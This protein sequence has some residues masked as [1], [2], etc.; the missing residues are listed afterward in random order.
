MERARVDLVSNQTGAGFLPSPLPENV[1][2]GFVY[3]K[4][5]DS[6]KKK[7]VHDELTLHAIQLYIQ[8]SKSYKALTSQCRKPNTNLLSQINH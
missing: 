6:R 2:K 1:A 5:K 3:F 4:T 8:I 7:S